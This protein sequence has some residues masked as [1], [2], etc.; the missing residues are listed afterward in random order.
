MS[1]LLDVNVLIAWGWDDHSHNLRARKWIGSVLKTKATKLH[2]CSIT[3]IGFIRVSLQ[4]TV[5][6]IEIQDAAN[7]LENLLRSLKSHH[8]FLP[9]DLSSRRIFPAWCKAAKHTTD[10]HLLALAEEHNLK[11]ATLD[12]GI[13][14]AFVI[15]E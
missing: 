5:P 1:Y 3:E 4:K 9:D 15:P 12:T 10:S 11:L 7:T 14:G 13:P 2:T 8:S 6:R